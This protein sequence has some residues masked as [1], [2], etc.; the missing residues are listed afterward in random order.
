MQRILGGHLHFWQEERK[1][2]LWGRGGRG[3]TE[4]E[5]EGVGVVRNNGGSQEQGSTLL[6]QPG[7]LNL[8][9]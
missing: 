8:L 9:G 1:V 7:S 5:V 6:P 3:S 4:A 2:L